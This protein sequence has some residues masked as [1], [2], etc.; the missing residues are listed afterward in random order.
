M[1]KSIDKLREDRQ[2]L[3]D[4]VEAIVALAQEENRDLT[5]EETSEIDSITGKNDGEGQLAEIDAKIERLSRIEAKKAEAIKSRVQDRFDGGRVAD[6]SRPFVVPASARKSGSVKHFTGPEAEKNAYIAGHFGLAVLSKREASFDALESMG[7]NIKAAM[8]TDNNEKGGYLVPNPL[9]AAIVTLVEQWGAFRRNVGNVWDLGNGNRSVPKHGTDF[10]AYWVGE[11]AEGTATDAALKLVKLD[12]KKLMVLGRVSNEMFE[13]PIVSFGD[14]L[15]GSIARACA[16]AEDNAGF[17]GDGTSTYGGIVGL[18]SAL[19]A[20]SVATALAN[21]N[22]LA[23]LTVDPIHEAMGKLPN[24]EGIMPKWYMH[25][26]VWEN[27][28]KRLAFGQGDPTHFAAGMPQLFMGYPVEFVNVMPQGGPTTDLASTIVAYFGD[29]AMAAAMGEAR[30]LSI[31]ASDAPYFTSDATAIRGTRRL[32]I[33]IHET[34]T[35]NTAGAIVG[36][37]LNAA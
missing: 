37:K 25:K 8:T 3:L 32:D 12:A 31:A 9:E 33:V 28:F 36:V 7:F 5:N 11:N 24:Y 10:T 27:G 13:D 4:H 30:G 6:E 14:Y 18:K 1:Y 19:N 23:E 15:T 21:D 20:G 26:S 34:G 29:L 22:T 17:N 35:S 2:A 16:Y